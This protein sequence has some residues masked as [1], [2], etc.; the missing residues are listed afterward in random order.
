MRLILL[1]TFPLLLLA[2]A[3][4][5][6]DD[7]PGPASGGSSPADDTL[8]AQIAAIL[9]AQ[10]EVPDGLQASGLSY[11]T[12]EQLAG[13]S[14]EELERLNSIG[15]LLGAE[16]TFLPTAE[17]PPDT[18]GRGG[19]Q[20][21]A[22]VHADRTGAA[23]TFATRTSAART[24]DWVANYADLSDV[25]ASEMARPIGDESLW[26][27]VTGLQ[28]CELDVP[29][30]QPAPTATCVP[31]KAVIDHIMV[32]A[33][34][35]FVYLSVVSDQP[36]GAIADVFAADIQRWAQLVVDRAMAEFPA[37]G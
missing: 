15:R 22:S 26:L 30:G 20:N 33:G 36:Q 1:L 6:G 7:S 37:A 23:D 4:K 25:T 31:R 27:R 28:E 5:N 11:S 35:T 13:P 34:R 21:S 18:P 16:V 32:R 10:S 14:G 12:N 9:L 8:E 24:N 29:T 19:I 2:A 17:I 3:C